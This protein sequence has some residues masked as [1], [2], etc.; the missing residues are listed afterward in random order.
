MK[1]KED[2]KE[3]N[4]YTPLL[5]ES[6]LQDDEDVLDQIL[7][8]KEQKIKENISGINKNPYESAGILSMIFFSWVYP[9]IKVWNRSFLITFYQ[10]NS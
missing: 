4:G 5:N 10:L 3:S 9:V 8:E 1:R 2:E 6:T 7:E